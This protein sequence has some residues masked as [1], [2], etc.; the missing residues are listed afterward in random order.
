M[1]LGGTGNY[2]QWR[3]FESIGGFV[4]LIFLIVCFGWMN[5]GFGAVFFYEKDHLAE[6]LRWGNVRIVDFSR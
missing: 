5:C 6:E 4:V 2:K 1:K 3:C